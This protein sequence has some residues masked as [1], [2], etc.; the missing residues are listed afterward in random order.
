[1]GAI[2]NIASVKMDQYDPTPDDNSFLLRTDVI[3]HVRIVGT[4]CQ[5]QATRL[6]LGFDEPVDP[7]W[8]EDSRNYHIVALQG[9]RRTIRVK[10]AV[11]HAATHTVTLRPA[12]NVNVHKIFEIE[13]EGRR[14]ARRDRHGGRLAGRSEWAR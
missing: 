11:Y 2:T 1:V 10:S 14:C 8:A 6:V 12:Q 7:A 5:Q 13:S 9:S 4:G 3:S